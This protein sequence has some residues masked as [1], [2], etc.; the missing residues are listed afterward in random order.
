M[1]HPAKGTGW[2]LQHGRPAINGKLRL[3]VKDDKHLL[4][5]VV[6]VMANP[7]FRFEDAPVQEAQVGVQR[8]RI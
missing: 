4:A 1:P 5:L 8:V 3:A 6:K 2:S 7:T